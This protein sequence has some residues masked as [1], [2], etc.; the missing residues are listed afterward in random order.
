MCG[1][2]L[3]NLMDDV[4]DNGKIFNFMKMLKIVVFNLIFFLRF[5]DYGKVGL[6]SD[7]LIWVFKF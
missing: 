4:Y 3:L 6:I 5:Y 2:K 1:E 7:Y